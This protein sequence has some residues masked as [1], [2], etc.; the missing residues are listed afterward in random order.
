MAREPLRGAIVPF[1]KT[2]LLFLALGL[3]MLLAYAFG[4][5]CGLMVWLFNLPMRIVRGCRGSRA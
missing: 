5:V 1:I 2:G 4:M 3:L